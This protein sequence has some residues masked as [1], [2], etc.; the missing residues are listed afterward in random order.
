VAELERELRAL[1]ALVELPPE[2]DLVPAVR[3][4]LAEPR[5]RAWL[6]PMAIAVAVLALALGVAFAVPQARSAILRLLGLRGVEI[7]LVDRL[8]E[9]RLT[10]ELGIGRE[11]SAAEARRL[12]RYP[13]PRSELL[14]E[15]DAVHLTGLRVTYLYG[16]PERVRLLLTVL[17]GAAAAPGLVKKVASPRTRIEAVS[18][19]GRPGYW[20]EGAP[21]IL[22]YQDELGRVREDRARLAGNVLLWERGPLTLRLE[23]RLTKEQALQIASSVR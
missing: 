10:R 3:A 9:V 12:L 14:G 7:E 5:R 15:P 20:L 6:R 17:P 11:V 21:H 18:V 4:R 2:R 13:L 1:G 8:P 16:T 19:D 23:G 22:V